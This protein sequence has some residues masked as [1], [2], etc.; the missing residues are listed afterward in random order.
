LFAWLAA[1]LAIDG[2]PSSALRLIAADPVTVLSYGDAAVLETSARR[3]LLNSLGQVDPYFRTAEVGVTA[4][5]GLAGE[6]LAADFTAILTDQ[7]DGT[8]RLLTVFEALTV[9]RPVLSLRPL[10]RAIA[11]DATRPEWQRS[12]A[13]DAY[14]NGAVDPAHVRRQMFNALNA[15]TASVA[16]EAVRARLAGGFAPGD[17]TVADVRSVLADYRRSGSDNMMGR[18]Y[19]LQ[20]RLETEPMPEL[21]NDPIATWLPPRNDRDRDHSIEIHHLLDHALAREIRDT[22]GLSAS[23]IWRWVANIRRESW[24]EL[25]DNTVKALAGWL[26]GPRTG[27]RGRIFRR[28][29]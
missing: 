20:K 25:K 29:S 10:L 1:H 15:E 19:S 23:T 2:D 13:V 27:T 24:S 26:V 12:R 16:R 4:V 22:V 11:L 14:L 7:A 3:A 17:L 6:D 18:L 8:H 21:F 28:N 5:G 9:G